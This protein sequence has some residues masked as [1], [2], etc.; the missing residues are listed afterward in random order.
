MNETRFNSAG[1]PIEFWYNLKT[2]LVEAGKQSHSTDLVGPFATEEE[3]R[4]APK[5]IAERSQKWR[6]EENLED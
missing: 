2:G 4:K 6:N 1:E 3:A 5:I